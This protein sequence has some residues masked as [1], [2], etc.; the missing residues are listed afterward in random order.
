MNRSGRQQRKQAKSK[1]AR[2]ILMKNSDAGNKSTDSTFICTFERFTTFMVATC[3]HFLI[4]RRYIRS[5][6]ML[7]LILSLIHTHTHSTSGDMAVA[8]SQMVLGDQNGYNFVVAIHK[9][10]ELYNDQ[11]LN[12]VFFFLTRSRTRLFILCDYHNFC[13]RIPINL[14]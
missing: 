10:S 4:H 3:N 13:I 7:V 8:G 14:I 6:L 9:W 11:H 1:T 12:V 2:S 5:H